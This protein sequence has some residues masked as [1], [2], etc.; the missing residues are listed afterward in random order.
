MKMKSR[1]MKKSK[2]ESNM[3]MADMEVEGACFDAPDT[4]M[5]EE[6]KEEA[7]ME[8]AEEVVV[9]EV[10]EQSCD[11]DGD[12][13]NDDDG[14][15]DGDDDDGDDADG[16]D[17]DGEK[18]KDENEEKDEAS[19]DD[20]GDWQYTPQVDDYTLVPKELEGKFDRLDPDGALR[21]TIIHPGK[22]WKKRAQ[23]ALLGK[24]TTSTLEGDDQ[25]EE[26]TRAFDLLDAL[27]RSGSLSV[28]DASLHVVMAATHCFD[29]TLVDTVVQDNVNPIE[30]VERSSLIIASTIHKKKV[31]DLIRPSQLERVKTYN[32]QLF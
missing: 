2:E 6:S 1:K 14:G 21:P 29:K 24:A 7:P 9:E 18:D 26:K 16:E 5:C 32:P 25:A 27:S 23:A 11:D 22:V 28:Q 4:E 31:E 3:M 20:S 13:D 12:G 19:G 8:S 10:D 30:K 15:D 17:D